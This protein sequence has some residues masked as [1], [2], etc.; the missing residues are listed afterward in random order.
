VTSVLTTEPTSR[1]LG[2]QLTGV[3]PLSDLCDNLI[4]LEMGG[5]DRTRRTIRVLKTRGRRHDP[6][7]REVEIGSGGAR[8]A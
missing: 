6:Q 2:V 7:V 8:I 3:T 1:A 5:E 4:Q